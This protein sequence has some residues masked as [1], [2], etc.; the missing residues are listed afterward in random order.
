M[1]SI[2]NEGDANLL[3][4]LM[5]NQ[6]N[7]TSSDTSGS[8]NPFQIMML[9]S[10][11]QS[12]PDEVP[13]SSPEQ[14]KIV[15]NEPI[16]QQDNVLD[17]SL[18]SQMN[19]TQPLPSMPVDLQQL[20]ATSTQ[21]ENMNEQKEA[22]LATD[23]QA[24]VIDPSS[25]NPVAVQSDTKF[26][27]QLDANM[28][29]TDLLTQ[30]AASATTASTAKLIQSSI[31]PVSDALPANTQ[32]P[33]IANTS[34]DMQSSVASIPVMQSQNTTNSIPIKTLELSTNTLLKEVGSNDKSNKQRLDG[35]ELN[36][37]SVSSLQPSTLF[38][39]AP[40]ESSMAIQPIQKMMNV[41]SQT[42]DLLSPEANKYVSALTQLGSMINAHTSPTPVQLDKTTL[43]AAPSD[44]FANTLQHLQPEMTV[45]IVPQS[46]DSL[47]KEAYEAKI[48]IYP[49]ELGQVLAKLSVHNNNAQ[50]VILTENDHVKQVVESN[51]SQLK[52]QFQQADI[53]LTQVQVETHSASSRDQFSNNQNNNEQNQG[54]SYLSDVNKLPNSPEQSKKSTDSIIDTYA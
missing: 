50:L 30:Q 15:K 28:S 27:K 54:K 45:N 13:V 52:Q 33:T 25:I 41:S 1:T 49:P 6:T 44:H 36:P 51:L 35:K 21:L 11:S 39:S 22:L 42:N 2:S 17:P 31:D 34:A 14:K 7:A 4:I 46:I 53:N 5:K 18:I 40:I 37:S 26:R 12:Q 20:L 32:I 8:D 3:K 43:P 9:N 38:D 24:Q 16:V 10:M 19:M 23:T 29:P 47:N 48:K